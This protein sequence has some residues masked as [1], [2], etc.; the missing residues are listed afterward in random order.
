MASG[1]KTDEINSKD[2]IP[3]LAVLQITP[4]FPPTIL[5][6]QSFV[7]VTVYFLSWVSFIDNP[8][9]KRHS[10]S[11]NSFFQHS[12]PLSHDWP[13][14]ALGSSH[15]LFSNATSIYWTPPVCQTLWIDTRV[16]RWATCGP[17]PGRCGDGCTDT[18]WQCRAEVG[19]TL[20]ACG[21]WDGVGD[22]LP[23]P[24]WGPCPT[25]CPHCLA[26]PSSPWSL[27]GW[28]LSS[29]GF[30]SNVTSAKKCSCPSNLQ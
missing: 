14:S 13:L 30:I 7:T 24:G 27:P 8:K 3:F 21:R 17:S 20:Q 18:R 11:G 1:T 25:A 10:S 19:D 4:T 23:P 5:W 2:K 12:V 9:I 28:L 29:S 26:L 16:N 15:L 6:S 22:C